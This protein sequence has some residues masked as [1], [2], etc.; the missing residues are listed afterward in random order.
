[1]NDTARFSFAG[2]GRG[3]RRCL[4]I[5]LSVFAYG[6]VFGVLARQAGL[7]LVESAFMSGWVF[8]GASQFVA[9]DLW[10]SPLPVP[11]VILTTLVLNLRH[12]LMGAAVYPWFSSLR[13][14]QVYPT[15][16]FMTDENW[17]LS[18]RHYAAGERDGGFLLG[19]GLAIYLSWFSAAV[20]GQMLGASIPDPARWG[21]DFAFTAVFA[22]MLVGMWKGRQDIFP[23]L[24]AALVALLTSYLLP[25]KW[26]ILLGGI[27]GSLAGALADGKNPGKRSPVGEPEEQADS[28]PAVDGMIERKDP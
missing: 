28:Q 3:F 25:G 27:A 13:P 11:A 2:V 9:L 4:P 22:A 5:S 18:M 23:W 1:M 7:S 21:L 12:V 19:S 10:V 8:A 17:A 14:R 20:V 16:Y 24:V 26:Y 6:M 15:L